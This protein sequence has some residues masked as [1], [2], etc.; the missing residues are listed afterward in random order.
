MI[1]SI[2]FMKTFVT[3]TNEKPNS[4]ALPMLTP[5]CFHGDIRK[6]L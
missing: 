5:A 4:N 1:F 3:G 2:F 6:Y